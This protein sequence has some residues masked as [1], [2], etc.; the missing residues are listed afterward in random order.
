MRKFMT[1]TMPFAE[2]PDSAVARRLAL[3]ISNPAGG[4]SEPGFIWS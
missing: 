2:R 3:A 1:G 4:L